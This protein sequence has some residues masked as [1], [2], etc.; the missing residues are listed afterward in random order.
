MLALVG[1][2]SNQVF[3]IGFNEFKMIDAILL[4][5]AINGMIPFNKY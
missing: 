4:L 5:I 1:M 3:T 2:V